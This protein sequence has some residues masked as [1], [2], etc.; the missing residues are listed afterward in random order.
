MPR[1][2]KITITKT[3]HGL[4]L[5]LDSGSRHVLDLTPKETRAVVAWMISFLAEIEENIPDNDVALEL[6]GDTR[7]QVTP[8]FHPVTKQIALQLMHPNLPGFLASLSEEE[9]RNLHQTIG[10]M[11]ETPLSLRSRSHSN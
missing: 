3:Q 9:A 4:R 10:E 1:N 11:I 8:G 7:L 6:S 5:S 2:R